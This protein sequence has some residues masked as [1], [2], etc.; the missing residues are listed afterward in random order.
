MDDHT[1]IMEPLTTSLGVRVKLSKVHLLKGFQKAMAARKTVAAR[2]GQACEACHNQKARC[3]PS[4][5]QNLCEKYVSFS[6]VTFEG[7]CLL[8]EPAP[9]KSCVRR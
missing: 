6:H 1:F 9:R 7:I 3:R 2:S 4:N 5:V 8:M